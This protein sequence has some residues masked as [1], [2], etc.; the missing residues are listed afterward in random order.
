L[1]P[2]PAAPDTPVIV[3]DERA[4]TLTWAP[5]APAGIV[6]EPETDGVLE[7]RPIAG[8]AAPLAYNVYDVS[9]PDAE[10][11]SPASALKL[12]KAP[13]GETTFADARVAWDQR[14]CY[15]VRAVAT[16]N[17]LPIESGAAAPTCETPTDT[18]P[19]AAPKGLQAVGGAASINL[20]WDP[21]PEKDLAGYVVLRG[22]AVTALQPITPQPIRES[23]F[24]DAV[25]PGL[26]YFYEVT[27][28]DKAGNASPPSAPVDETA[29]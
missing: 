4:L 13:I 11:G 12:T 1:V 24:I 8:L 2:P 21:N 25:Q 28:V 23:K 7:S 10:A 29:R 18:F 26:H 3:Y 17:G 14:R 9:E 15:V 6:P 19:P 22:A 16:I 20:I 5:V 27:A